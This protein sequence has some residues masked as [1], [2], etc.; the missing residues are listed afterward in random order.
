MWG[1][2]GEVPEPAGAQVKGWGSGE[3]GAWAGSLCGQVSR[4]VTGR[5]WEGPA[6]RMQ[7]TAAGR[8]TE[9]RRAM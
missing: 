8:G 7:L 2:E 4:E 5:E 3:E 6:A 9:G 1:R